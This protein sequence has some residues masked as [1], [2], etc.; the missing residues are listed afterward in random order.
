MIQ[1]RD[2][3]EGHPQPP[4]APAGAETDRIR[5]RIDQGRFRDKIPAED[6]AAVPLGTDAEAGGAP[7]PAEPVRDEPPAGPGHAPAGHAAGPVPGAGR[8]MTALALTLVGV[9]VLGILVI[10]LAGLV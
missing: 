10:L 6:P 2:T 4:P 1:R 9:V 5:S 3:R 8:R 7:M